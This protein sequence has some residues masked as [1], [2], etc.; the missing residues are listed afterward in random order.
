MSDYLPVEEF[1]ELYELIL[2]LL[3]CE[4]IVLLEVLFEKLMVLFG[5]GWGIEQV[6]EGNELRNVLED[7]RLME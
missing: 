2:L 3:I 1:L 5:K 7:L 6:F 4:L